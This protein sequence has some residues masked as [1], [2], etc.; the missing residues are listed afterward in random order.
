MDKNRRLQIV[1]RLVCTGALVCVVPAPAFAFEIVNLGLSAHG[2]DARTWEPGIPVVPEHEPAK[3]NDGSFHSYWMV[4]PENR[5]P[6][7]VWSG[8]PR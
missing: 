4:R 6:T 7:S 1:I 3:A 2:A 5:L 8:P